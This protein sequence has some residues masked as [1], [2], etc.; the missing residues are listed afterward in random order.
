LF[1]TKVLIEDS[2]LISGIVCKKTIG[3][4]A[5]SLLHVVF[6]EL[7]YETA[8]LMYGNFQTCVNNWLM[9]EANSIGIGD[10]IADP[11]TYVDIQETIRKAKVCST[12]YLN[13]GQFNIVT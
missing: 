11:Q 9:L 2:V 1:V 12:T 10:T 13:K 8:G 4:S 5:G 6:T 3:T 7:G